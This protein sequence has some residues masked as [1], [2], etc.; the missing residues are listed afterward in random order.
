MKQE[1]RFPNARTN[2]RQTWENA[3]FDDYLRANFV[4]YYLIFKEMVESF[5][6]PVFLRYNLW[7][8]KLKF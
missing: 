3:N 6:T 8:A 7:T 5:Q 2:H 1:S 4:H